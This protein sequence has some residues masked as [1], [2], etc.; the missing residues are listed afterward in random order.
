LIL[1]RIFGIFT[2]AFSPLRMQSR[3]WDFLGKIIIAKRKKLISVVKR[4]LHF[5][6]AAS[7]GQMC[8]YNLG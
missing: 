3:N 1:S 2:R 8:E 4:R 6:N 7:Y 5:F